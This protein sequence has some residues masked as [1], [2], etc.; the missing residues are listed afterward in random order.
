MVHMSKRETPMTERYW[1][2]VGGA[3][4]EEFLLVAGAPGTARRLVDAVILQQCE[5]RRIDLGGRRAVAIAGHE[6]VLVQANRL[7]MSLL[8]QAL[9]SRE[10]IAHFEPRS[11]RTVALCSAGDAVLKDI[12]T[13][14]G[15]EVVVDAGVGIEPGETKCR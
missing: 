7:G 14:F 2:S 12:A 8:G 6:V 1:T 15:I 9:F 11:V 5:A 10:L 3:L 4:I 13:K